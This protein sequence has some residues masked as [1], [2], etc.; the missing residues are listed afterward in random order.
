MCEVGDEVRYKLDNLIYEISV[1]SGDIIFLKGV[2]GTFKTIEFELVDKP[3]ISKIETTTFQPTKTYLM[4][5][6]DEYVVEYERR[7]DVDKI[8][9]LLMTEYNDDLT[10]K[11]KLITQN[12]VKIYKLVPVWQRDTRRELTI[13][14]KNAIKVKR[15]RDNW[16]GTV[17]SFNLVYDNK[18]DV[19]SLYYRYPDNSLSL[20][21]NEYEVVE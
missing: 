8:S 5:H 1:V 19:G 4:E 3:T 20:A 9:E 16:V 2:R 10:A 21:T 11:N 12:I 15:I 6:K 18:E 14:E 13:K 17:G 7:S